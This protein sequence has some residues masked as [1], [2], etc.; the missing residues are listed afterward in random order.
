MKERKTLRGL[1]LLFWGWDMAGRGVG[2]EGEVSQV[3]KKAPR[4]AAC[5]E[6]MQKRLAESFEEIVE[7]FV[8]EAK[9]GSCAHVKLTSEL[10]ETA[11][12]EKK[13]QKKGSAERMLEKWAKREKQETGKRVRG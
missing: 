13:A 7:G 3:K 4:P 5:K 9:K 12:R 8:K 6:L 2:Q 11:S 10:L 1:P